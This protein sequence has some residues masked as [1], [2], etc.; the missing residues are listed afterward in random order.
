MEFMG[1]WTSYK[2]G[3]QRLLPKDSIVSLRVTSSLLRLLSSLLDLTS[4]SLR[5]LLISHLIS[6]K[7]PAIW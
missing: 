6:H 4:L 7:E 3:I 1:F 5:L 2:E